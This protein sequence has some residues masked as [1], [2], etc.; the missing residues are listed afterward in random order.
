MVDRQGMSKEAYSYR[1]LNTA[2]A[3][4]K[5]YGQ[6][7]VIFVGGFASN[8]FWDQAGA[9]EKARE[10]AKRVGREKVVIKRIKV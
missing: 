5:E 9:Q 8:V 4:A 2:V 7:F 10:H 1:V 6:S 3:T